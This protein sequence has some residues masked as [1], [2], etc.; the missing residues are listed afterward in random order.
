MS[1]LA[2]LIIQDNLPLLISLIAVAESLLPWKVTYSWVLRI[3][4]GQFSS[5]MSDSLPPRR[6][7]HARLTC[8][9]PGYG[10]PVYGHPGCIY[11]AYHRLLLF[12]LFEFF[13]TFSSFHLLPY[14]W[15]AGTHRHTHTHTHTHRRYM[16]YVSTEYINTLVNIMTINI[17]DPFPSGLQ[18]LLFFHL[19]ISFSLILFGV[20]KWIEYL[21]G[22]RL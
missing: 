19:S 20:Q 7:Q 17:L 6:L 2:H 12:S 18:T 15:H 4:Y 9:S 16:F 14:A 22:P 10:H 8:P 11:S 21:H 13:Q 3:R 5:V 1:T